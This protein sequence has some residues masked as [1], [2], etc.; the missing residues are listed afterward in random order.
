MLFYFFS[1]S[2]YF[3]PLVAINVRTKHVS[4]NVLMQANNCQQKELL[5]RWERLWDWQIKT[6][7]PNCC[8][9]LSQLK[10]KKVESL[11][12]LVGADIMNCWIRL[13]YSNTEA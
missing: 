9:G 1:F 6:Y 4:K 5:V 12:T 11:L 3:F 13:F 10:K 7:I 8:V 2:S